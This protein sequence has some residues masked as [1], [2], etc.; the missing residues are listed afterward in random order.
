[1]LFHVTADTTWS[2]LPLSGL[3]VDMLR[4]VAALAGTPDDVGAEARDAE[5]PR[6]WRRASTLDGFGAFGAPPADARAVPRDYRRARHATS[7]RRASTARSTRAS[8]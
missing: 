3:F 6:P 4:R 8:P 5:Q 1:M 2:N 7:I